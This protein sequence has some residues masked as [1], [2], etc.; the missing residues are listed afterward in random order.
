MVLT[1]DDLQKLVRKIN[2]MHSYVYSQSILKV[3]I[4]FTQIMPNHFKNSFQVH[5]RE[6]FTLVCKDRKWIV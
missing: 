3:C 4:F 1:V 6:D 5:G 2:L